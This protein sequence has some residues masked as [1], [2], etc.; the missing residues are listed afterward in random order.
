MGRWG[1]N[2]L[3]VL[4]MLLLAPEL[5]GGCGAVS[6][7]TGSSGPRTIA[8]TLRDDRGPVQDAHVTLVT[9]E[10]DRCV[11]IARSVRPPTDQDRQEL[12]QCTREVGATTTN[13]AGAYTFPNVPPGAYVV[14]LVWQLRPGQPVP[15]TPV[16]KQGEYAIAIVTNSD[17]TWTVTAVSEIV[18]L[19]GQENVFRDLAYQPPAP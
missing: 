5:G 16:F 18:A 11:E 13:S 1:I 10:S 4:L 3:A 19:S 7:L 6:A 17:G 8:G 15:S 2:P 14:Q 9:F 12:A